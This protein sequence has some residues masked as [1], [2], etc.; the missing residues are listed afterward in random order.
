MKQ[1]NSDIKGRLLRVPKDGLYI[2]LL[3]RIE[4]CKRP[5]EEIIKFPPLFS[6]IASCFSIPKER[7]WPLLHFLADLGFIEVI[8]GH[9]IKIKFEVKNGR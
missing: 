3:E 5:G 7:V 1:Y 8:F 2:I 4:S 9:G 6:K